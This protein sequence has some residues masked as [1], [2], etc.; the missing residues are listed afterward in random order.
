MTFVLVPGAGGEGWYWHRVV[1]LLEAAGHR[2]IA[3]DLPTGDADAGLEDYADA[4]VA[5]LG[6]HAGDRDGA[7]SDLAVSRAYFDARCAA[8]GLATQP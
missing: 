4:I 1:P 7:A 2:A 8:L 3:V 6:R 5:A